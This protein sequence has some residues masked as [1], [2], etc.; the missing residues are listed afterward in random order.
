MSLFGEEA[1]KERARRF[2]V[3]VTRAMEA[4]LEARNSSLGMAR[5]C[6]E[7]E[8]TRDRLDKAWVDLEICLADAQLHRD[9]YPG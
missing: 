7:L 3:E 5:R 1:E 4:V 8:E 2:V 9:S 6:R